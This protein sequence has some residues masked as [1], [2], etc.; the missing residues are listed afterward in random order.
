M[1]ANYF[2]NTYFHLISGAHCRFASTSAS[3][4]SCI[5]PCRCTKGCDTTTGQCINGGICEDGHPSSRKWTGTAC[6]TGS[7]LL[8]NIVN[9]HLPKAILVS[10]MPD[11][12]VVFNKIVNLHRPKTTLVNIMAAAAEFEKSKILFW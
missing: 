6:Q 2:A 8:M 1:N 3:Q 4:G 10:I 7:C 11:R 5:F 12:F 9:I